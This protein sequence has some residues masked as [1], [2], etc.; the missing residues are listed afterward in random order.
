[1][2]ALREHDADLA[3]LVESAMAGVTGSVEKLTSM[4][5][6][7]AEK[8]SEAVATNLVKLA[9]KNMAGK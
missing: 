2:G 8:I 3:D 4:V 5:P 7:I 9:F 6:E 1:V